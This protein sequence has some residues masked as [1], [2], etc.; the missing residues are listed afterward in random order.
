MASIERG[1]KQ[2]LREMGNSDDRSLCFSKVCSCQALRFDGLEG[3]SCRIHRRVQPSLELQVS[4]GFSTSESNTKSIITSKQVSGSI[5]DNC[6]QME[7]DILDVRSIQQEQRTTNNDH[8]IEQIS[9]RPFN[10]STS[11]PNRKSYSASVDNWV[12][13][14]LTKNW[15]LE[16]IKLLK[17][18]WRKST[19][20]TYKAPIKR[21]I[22][23][24]ESNKVS[25]GSPS[26]N[27]VARFLANVLISENLA[28]NTILLHKSAISTF[29]SGGPSENF[30]SNFLVRQ[31]L[32]AIS[33]AKPR[34]IKTLV[35]D[36]QILLDWLPARSRKQ[37]LFEIS[38]RTA[39]LLL[40]VS[41]R[42]IHDLTLLRTSGSY[43]LDANDEIILWP[44]FGS[45]T[46]RALFRQSG[47]RLSKHTNK[48]LCPVSLIRSYI[49]IIKRKKN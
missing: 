36:T 25:P 12:W 21:W 43:F 38:R 28:Y 40:L 33:I 45:K 34:E 6:T 9:N 27:E 14:D 32:K 29:C 26:A 48:W 17:Q 5:R 39:A 2:D 23:W 46:D 11:E 47:W 4:M 7:S 42:R 22:S 41:G 20:E 49:D 37:S 3:S 44:T 18:S 31:I 10:G 13:T 19:L 8:R 1:K 24:C 16:E 30:S 35:W 15:S